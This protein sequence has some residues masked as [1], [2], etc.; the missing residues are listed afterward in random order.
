MHIAVFTN[1]AYTANHQTMV[2]SN[3]SHEKIVELKTSCK[4]YE[5]SYINKAS[6][7]KHYH[8][9]NDDDEVD[10]NGSEENQVVM[11]QLS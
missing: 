6:G 8:T 11:E 2:N 10:V 7:F 4:Y 3:H 1:F 9:F 5:N